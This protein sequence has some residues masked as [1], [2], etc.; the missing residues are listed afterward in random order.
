MGRL[1]STFSIGK[2]V[3]GVILTKKNGT[4]VTEGCPFVPNMFVSRSFTFRR[5][6]CA[7]AA[8]AMPRRGSSYRYG[9]VSSSGYSS[10]RARPKLRYFLLGTAPTIS[11]AG[12]GAFTPSLFHAQV[13][14]M[15]LALFNTGSNL[16]T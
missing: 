12:L 9:G 2:V 13:F 4:W 6:R 1:N 5:R 7:S 15:F 8:A 10:V 11:S 3:H 16:S 14:E